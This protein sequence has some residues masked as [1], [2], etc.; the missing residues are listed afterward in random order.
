MKLGTGV[1]TALATWVIPPVALSALLL[2]TPNV[3]LGEADAGQVVAART[4]HRWFQPGDTTV[5]QTT[6]GTFTV[7]GIQ[8]VPRG[9]RLIVKDSTRDG[10]QV[11]TE[12]GTDTCADFS[13]N[14][15]GVLRA[16]PH[17]PVVLSH[18]VREGLWV[19]AGFWAFA[20]G[21]VFALVG[22][23]WLIERYGD[24]ERPDAG[25]GTA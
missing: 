18:A 7:A 4:E 6:S 24:C 17:G 3:L 14:Y 12:Q 1:V 16:V 8:S 25:E 11:C 9:Q 2:L 19:V 21:L 15:M 10:E 13:G 23:W 5:L 20:A 22:M